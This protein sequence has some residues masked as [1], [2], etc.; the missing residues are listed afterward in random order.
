[1][2]DKKEEAIEVYNALQV[3]KAVVAQVQAEDKDLVNARLAM[4]TAIARFSALEQAYT[5]KIAEIDANIKDVHMILLH[6]WD[7]EEKTFKCKAGSATVRTTKAVHVIDKRGLITTL[8]NLDKLPEC[9]RSLNLSYLR[10]LIEVDLIPFKY[11]CFEEHK[12]VVI[13]GAT[14]K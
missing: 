1:M 6:D 3:Q 13:K 9:I 5:D 14:E 11:A 7:I 10:K 8:L 12:N 4:E 2:I